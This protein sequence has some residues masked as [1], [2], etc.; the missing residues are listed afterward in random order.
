MQRETKRRVD[1]I[2]Q[3]RTAGRDDLVEREEA[4]LSVLKSTCRSN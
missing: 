1:S 3:F 4:Q 2:E